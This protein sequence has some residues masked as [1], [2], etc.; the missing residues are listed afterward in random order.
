[1]SQPQQR[2][3]FYGSVLRVKRKLEE[4]QLATIV[5][6]RKKQKLQDSLKDITS[7]LGKVGLKREEKLFTKRP[8]NVVRRVFRLVDQSSSEHFKVDQAKWDMKQSKAK[9][10]EKVLAG[11]KQSRTMKLTHGREDVPASSDNAGVNVDEKDSDNVPQASEINYINVIQEDKQLRS[12][13]DSWIDL[14]GDERALGF[15]YDYYYLDEAT[16]PS[17]LDVPQVLVGPDWNAIY[18]NDTEFDG[19]EDD[20][21]SEDSNAEGYY[22]NDYPEEITSSEDNYDHF[23]EYELPY[24]NEC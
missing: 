15:T 4:A 24:F 18:D 14:G 2:K 9:R 8:E 1:M 16:D 19:S 11:N 22:Q 12:I 10:R 6:A 7:A 3:P 5:V 20:F 13:P 23:E 17:K 21:D